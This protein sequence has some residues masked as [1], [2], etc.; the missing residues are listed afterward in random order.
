MNYEVKLSEKTIK[1]LDKTKNKDKQNFEV[2]INH[3]RNLEQ[4]PEHFGKPLVGK[5]KGLRSYRV[6]NFRIIYQTQKVNKIVFIVTIGPKRSIY[7]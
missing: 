5:L 7:E 2:I 4:N 6:G 1:F 3:L